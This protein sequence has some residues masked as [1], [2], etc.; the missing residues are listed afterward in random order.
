[1]L[2][3]SRRS[4]RDPSELSITDATERFLGR[5]RGGL[6]EATVREYGY[7][8][9]RFHE[10]CEEEGIEVVGDIHPLDFDDYLAYR[11]QA[12]VSP[13]TIQSQ[14]K[15]IR[16]WIEFLESLG[17]VDDGLADAVPRP[18]IPKGAE[19]SETKLDVK[20][21]D[22][23]IRFYRD[24][25]QHYGSVQHAIL[26]IIWFTGARLGAVRALD[27]GDVWLDDN[28]LAFRHRPETDTPLKN[29]PDGERV[30]AISQSTSDALRAYADRNRYSNRDDYGRLPFIT[31]AF[32][33]PGTNA[34]RNWTYQATQPCVRTDCPHEKQRS[35]CRWTKSNHASKCPSSRSPH[36]VRTGAITRM[37]NR[38]TKDRVSFRANTSQFAHYDM[39][40]EL[41]KLEHRDRDTADDLALDTENLEK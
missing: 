17:A 7:R 29:G 1:M 24:S 30:V 25:D 19:I 10:Y 27:L 41:Q 11:E 12:D 40:D 15:T 37:L 20:D 6:A 38:S 5:K 8:L 18:E 16:K 34:I 23:L 14:F 39:A 32:G 13:I 9:R 33:R 31:S 2:A 28:A 4:R 26:E 35:T 3:M 36:E 22:A 21:G